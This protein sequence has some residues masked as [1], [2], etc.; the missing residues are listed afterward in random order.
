MRTARALASVDGEIEITMRHALCGQP[1]AS[2]LLL[3]PP[4][5]AKHAQPGPSGTSRTSRRFTWRS[6]RRGRRDAR[7]ARVTP[8]ALRQEVTKRHLRVRVLEPGG[9]TTELGSHNTGA[10]REEIDNFYATT[11]ALAPEDIADGVACMVT[12]PRH[13]SIGELWIMPTD[14]A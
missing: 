3:P 9:V 10:V 12:R 1:K 2:T 5:Q 14:Q 7:R 13:A 4:T 8:G 11:E 6:N